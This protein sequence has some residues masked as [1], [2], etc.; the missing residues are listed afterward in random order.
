MNQLTRLQEEIDKLQCRYDEETLAEMGRV[1]QLGF[2]E[3]FVFRKWAAVAQVHELIRF[4][5][6]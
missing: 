2:A 1:C 6:G 5:S 3:H 4:A